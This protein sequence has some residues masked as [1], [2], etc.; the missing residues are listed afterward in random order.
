M[1]HAPSTSDWIKIPAGRFWMGGIE[2]DKFVTSV[3]LPRHEVVIKTSFWISRLPV[4]NG[5]WNT[6]MN[7]RS[8]LPTNDRLPV[9]G[10]NWNEA[11]DYCDR[12]SQ[13][14]GRLH[15]LP[16]EAEWEYVCRGGS[17]TI[18]PHGNDISPEHA[19]Y[20]YDERG[21]PVGPGRLSEAGSYQP[22]AFGVSDLLGNVCEW[23]IDP[24]HPHFIDAPCDGS[25]WTEAGHEG[26]RVIRGGAWDHLPRV[27]R[28]SWRDWAP[29]NARWDNLGF[30]VVREEV[31]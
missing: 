21:K 19:N 26:R 15:R 4:T 24:W 8:P 11:M 20:Y 6:V 23:V 30:R 31:L 17:I 10:V 2:D 16:S 12:L 1:D 3:E 13:M 9:V 14:T 29:E 18:F 28:S 27:L 7:S 22:N 5:Q 25:A